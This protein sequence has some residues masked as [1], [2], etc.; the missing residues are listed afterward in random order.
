MPDTTQGKPRVGGLSRRAA[1]A[2]L[3]GAPL[4]LHA[5]SP[6]PAEVT[7]ELPGVR[8][9]GSGRLTFF[10]M[11]IYVARLWVVGSFR[12]DAFAQ[13]PLALELEYARTLRGELIAERSLEEMRRSGHI[14]AEQGQAWL[15][16]MGNMFPDVAKSDRLTA[17]HRPGQP[18][19]FFFNA[20][21]RGE[22]A[23][24]EFGPRFLAIWLAPQT[25]EPELR[26]ALL[27][28]RGSTS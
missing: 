17:L 10:A 7:A 20:K 28:E 12:A 15:A 19:R 21:L 16:A 27:G 23:D 13:C 4:T 1:L 9:L 26:Q 3:M 8:L 22:L 18:L 24:A 25:S 5:R 11:P 2:L 6:I 14:G